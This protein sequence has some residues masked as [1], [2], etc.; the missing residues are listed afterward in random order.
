[1]ILDINIKKNKTIWYI[2]KDLKIR[3]GRYI[4]RHNDFIYITAKNNKTILLLE[5]DAFL[6]VEEAN[7]C[8]QEHLLPKINDTIENIKLGIQNVFYYYSILHNNKK[9]MTRK[10]NNK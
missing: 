10:R 3:K 2:R 9:Y 7:K 8:A 6:T 5:A 1:M 4:D